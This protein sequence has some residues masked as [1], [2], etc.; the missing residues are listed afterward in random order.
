MTRYMTRD[1]MAI[2]AAIAA[3]LAAA[4]ILLPWRSSWS[5]TNVA[6]LLVVVV[7]AVAA[8]GNRAAGALDRLPK[9]RHHIF[10]HALGPV[11]REGALQ[12]DDPVGRERLDVG[13]RVELRR[14]L[15]RHGSVSSGLGRSLGRSG[16]QF[17][18]AG[19]GSMALIVT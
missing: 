3:P 8:T 14:V 4:V 19:A 17:E 18:P 16:L 2:V 6:L 12:A 1:R 9:R 11:A 7:V 5:N 13:G 15:S 10:A